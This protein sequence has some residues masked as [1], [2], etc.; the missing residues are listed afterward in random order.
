MSNFR[1]ILKNFPEKDTCIIC[2][3]NEDMECVLVPVDNAG[4][5]SQNPVHTICIKNSHFRINNELKIIYSV[6]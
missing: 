3:T 2:K 6:F 1:E 5:I 4:C